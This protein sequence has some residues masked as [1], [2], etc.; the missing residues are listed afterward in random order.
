MKTTIYVSIIFTWLSVLL[1]DLAILKISCWLLFPFLK[2]SKKF[3][4]DVISVV[5]CINTEIHITIWVKAQQNLQN[6]NGLPAKTQHICAILSRVLAVCLMEGWVLGYPADIQ[7]DLS[8]LGTHHFAVLLYMY[9]SLRN[10]KTNKMACAPSKHSDQ[11]G[12]L[13]SLIRV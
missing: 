4:G 7:P 12:H 11:P 8:P 5:K 10:D 2:Y 9:M 6:E 13:P 3:I 1:N